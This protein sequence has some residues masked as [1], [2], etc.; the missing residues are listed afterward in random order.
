MHINTRLTPT[1]IT[2]LIAASEI[3]ICF[4]SVLLP[5]I[6]GAFQINEA[7]AQS[8]VS[9]GLFALGFSG[10]VYGAISDCV[11]RK[12]MF[13]I[14]I[15]VFCIASI[16]CVNAQ[17][18]EVFLFARFLQGIGSGASWIV[19]NACLKDIFFQDAYTR[20]MNYIHAIAGIIPAVA[21]ILGSKLAV[22]IGWRSCFL[23]LA[24]VGAITWLGIFFFQ[25]ET[26]KQKK[27]LSA[28]LIIDEYKTLAKNF[29]FQIYLVI[30]VISVMIIFVETSNNS[31]ILVDYLG[32]SPS[33]YGYYV[34]PGFIA[35]IIA[36][37][38]SSYLTGKV[39]INHLLAVGLVF[40]IL[41][42]I[43]TLLL[44][45][46]LQS[47]PLAVQLA[48]ASTYM[49]LGFIFGNAT[50][51]VVSSASNCPGS[52]SAI[53]IGLEMLFS[54][55][56]I[57]LESIFFDGSIVPVTQFTLVSAII[58]MSVLYL[59]RDFLQQVGTGSNPPSAHG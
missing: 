29:K 42:Q 52:A 27:Q 56:G 16:L 26:L 28:A 58:A 15:A 54:S 48:K 49:G 47:S 53:M 38:I 3:A 5:D 33:A 31:L 10:V 55:I 4:N 14:S 7:T 12:P 32:V 2:L 57:S 34:L 19:G 45:S 46:T 25:Q 13:L 36:N 43:A 30:K 59:S 11:G 20:V 22:V 40:I 37:L 41:S 6:K 39:N 35:Y 23:V 21:P 1:L 50:A 8:T 44:P 17:R 9:I 18:I 51:M 24:I